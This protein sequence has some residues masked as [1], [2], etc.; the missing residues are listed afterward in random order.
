MGGGKTGLILAGA[1]LLL[2]GCAADELKLTGV[3]ET[4][5]HSH[6]AEVGGKI[7]DFP[8]ELGQPLEAGDTVAVIDD[9]DARYALEQLRAGMEKKE[10]ALRE[11]VRGA[12]SAEIR[13]GQNN[14]ALA[15]QAVY[16][17]QLAAER[18]A[19]DYAD[20]LALHEQGALSAKALSDARYG[21]E[22]AD[23]AAAVAD[24]RLDSS[25]QSLALISQ[26]A[27]EEKI[28]QAQAEITLTA[29]QIRQSEANLAK[30]RVTAVSAGVVVSRNYLP[31]DIVAPG[32]NLADIAGADEK[33]VLAYQ[34]E[35][36]LA[37][38][39]YGQTITVRRG[40]AEYAGAVGYIDL[41]AQYTP[42]DMQT[43]A[44]RNKTSFK[45][46]VFLPADTGLKPGEQV[47][48]L[49]PIRKN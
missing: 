3:V 10:A 31:G 24:T 34:P 11:L 49:V 29:S 19:A 25:R 21:K 17:A 33:Y 7:V 20:A 18:A 36:Y 39:D 32:Y 48:L 13:Q 46:K 47:E 8:V 45:F 27:G 43:A 22:L 35:A 42:K 2:S 6:Y 44:N 37:D 26:G 14:V 1:L 12:D 16:T 5:I 23:A 4:V 38:L 41:K 28:A 30:Y 40:A 9:S 15:E